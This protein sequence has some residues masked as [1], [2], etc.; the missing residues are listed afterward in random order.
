MTTEE[1]IDKLTSSLAE[2]LSCTVSQTVPELVKQLDVQ[3]DTIKKKNEVI[4]DLQ[5]ELQRA[6]ERS[7]DE[8]YKVNRITIE[9]REQQFIARELGKFVKDV[10]N[11]LYEGQEV[12]AAQ[13]V[14]DLNG[15]KLN[16]TWINAYNYESLNDA[17]ESFK[18]AKILELS[19]DSMQF[20]KWGTS[21]FQKFLD[22][23]Y[24][25]VKS[26]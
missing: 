16:K 13:R 10:G 15:N 2:S 4:L 20:E 25:P 3:N 21:D 9:M 24:S 12:A 26:E 11:R 5:N 19:G 7:D 14:Y 22:W 18:E 17:V 6:I 1:L 23:L 8:E